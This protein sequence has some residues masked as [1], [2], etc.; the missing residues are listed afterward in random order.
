MPLKSSLEVKKAAE[1]KEEFFLSPQQVGMFKIKE[2]KQGNRKKLP[3]RIWL[4]LMGIK[5]RQAQT[6]SS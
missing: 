2:E 5:T 3:Q 6:F 4:G 1:S